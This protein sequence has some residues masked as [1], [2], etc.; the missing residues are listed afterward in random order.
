MTPEER[1][2]FESKLTAIGLGLDFSKDEAGVYASPATIIAAVIWQAAR[3][4]EAPTVVAMQSSGGAS[5]IHEWLMSD[6]TIETMT[7]TQA[8][9]RRAES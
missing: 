2:I 9:A 6:G 7:T 5:G 8:Q 3:A 4:P 1:A